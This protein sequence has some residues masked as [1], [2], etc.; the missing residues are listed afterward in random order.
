MVVIRNRS[1]VVVIQRLFGRA[2]SLSNSRLFSPYNIN[3]M[4]SFPPEGLAKP[5]HHRTIAVRIG[6]PAAGRASVAYR[7]SAV[8][9]SL[10]PRFH[11][12]TC[13]A[14]V[15]LLLALASGTGTEPRRP[16]GVAGAK[17]RQS[18]RTVVALA[19]EGSPS[20]VLLTP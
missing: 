8:M 18:A 12:T 5:Q 2:C 20:L 7:G 4:L 9:P 10:R 14:L 1:R 16:A 11:S 15:P 17:P 19:C 6:Q 3:L 13:R